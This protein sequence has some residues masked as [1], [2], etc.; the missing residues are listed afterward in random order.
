MR[1][2]DKIRDALEQAFPDSLITVIEDLP[3][4]ED[5]VFVNGQMVARFDMFFWK[6]DENPEIEIKIKAPLNSI[7]DFIEECEVFGDVMRAV[8]RGYE[9][10]EK[11]S[12]ANN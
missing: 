10:W 8:E 12:Q 6:Q 11:G 9:E 2:G 7:K 3:R 1:N 4:A 5:R